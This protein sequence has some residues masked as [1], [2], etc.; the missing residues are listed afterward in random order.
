VKGNKGFLAFF[1]KADDCRNRTSRED[2]PGRDAETIR[3]ATQGPNGQE[4]APG[5]AGWG[6]KDRPIAPIEKTL[7]W[8]ASGRAIR[9]KHKRPRLAGGS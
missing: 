1:G 4:G 2:K 3:N 9:T 8:A 5:T 6:T 7:I